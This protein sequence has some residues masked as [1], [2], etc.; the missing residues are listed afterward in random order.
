MSETFK[1]LGLDPSLV[2]AL[3]VEKITIPTDIQGRAIPKISLNKDCIMQSETGTGKTLA[4]LLPL[5]EKIKNTSKEMKAVILAPTHELVIQIQRQIERLS[6]NSGLSIRSTPIIGGTNITR[7]IDKLK[8][9]PQ[10]IVGSPGRIL[11]LIRKKKIKTQTIQMIILDEADRLMD[12]HNI[13]PVLG[14]IGSLHKERQLI[15]VSAT[16][17]Q[18]IID[19]AGNIMADPVLIKSEG[20]ESVPESISHIYLITEQRDK[21]ELLKKLIKNIKPPKILIFLN[22]ID[23]IDNLT[24]KLQYHGIKIESMHGTSQKMDRK[25]VMDDYRSGKL[26]ALIASDIAARG[27]Q[28]DGITYVFNMDIPEISKDYLHRAGRTGRNGL[29]GTVV[30]LAT[31]KEMPLINKI[32]KLNRHSKAHKKYIDELL[33]SIE[34][35]G[36]L[37][38]KRTTK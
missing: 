1:N 26:P 35:K 5:F 18:N 19:A 32:E 2:K 30:S 21:I 31:I 13:I 37:Y 38:F 9:K 34:S 16:L 10:I 28:M 11:E 7:Q 8:N 17:P 24:G 25:Q 20:G 29:K 27:L 15:I 14:I 33:D 36:L 6:Q 3:E 12:T 23:Q 22:S 4:Y